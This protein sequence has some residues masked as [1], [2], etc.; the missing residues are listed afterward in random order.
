MSDRFRP[1]SCYTG[2][3]EKFNLSTKQYLNQT[4]NDDLTDQQIVE[5]LIHY[6]RD[7]EAWFFSVYC[8][9]ILQSVNRRFFHG[10]QPMEKMTN[11][12]YLH[13]K[14]QDWHALRQYR[15]TG[16]LKAWLTTVATNLFMP[17]P[18][19]ASMVTTMDSD[20]MDAFLEEDN[21]YYTQQQEKL[22][23]IEKALDNL[24]NPRYRYVL[25]GIYC[26]QLPPQL[27]AEKMSITL[28]N[29]YNLHHRALTALKKTIS[30]Q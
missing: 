29:F 5:R 14:K 1:F 24:P 11:D 2:R 22:Q 7:M 13:L 20:A 16:T 19:A 18:D 27:L 30:Y 21:L 6:D 23:A 12:F 4:T 25:K 26:W 3:E 15:P 17:C 28:P 9:P 10:G 8:A